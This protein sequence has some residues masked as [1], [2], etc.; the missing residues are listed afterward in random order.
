V[1]RASARIFDGDRAQIRQQ[2]VEYALT[3]A[4]TMLNPA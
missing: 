1:T 4:L 3:S 2:A